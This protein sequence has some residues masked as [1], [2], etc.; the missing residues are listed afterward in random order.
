ML[1]IAKS[2]ISCPCECVKCYF[3]CYCVTLCVSLKFSLCSSNLKLVSLELVEGGRQACPEDICE[4]KF[5]LQWSEAFP[6]VEYDDATSVMFCKV[7]RSYPS[8]A[9]NGGS[10]LLFS[11]SF[12]Q[13]QPRSGQVKNLSTCPTGQVKKLL[14]VYPCYHSPLHDFC[15]SLLTQT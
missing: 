13:V 1:I 5:L 12:G 8:K 6:W 10:F 9:D 14:S 2:T 3:V 11:V 15:A 7:C 4:R